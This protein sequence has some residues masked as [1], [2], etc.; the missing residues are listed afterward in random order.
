MIAAV[1]RCRIDSCRT[2]VLPLTSLQ[3]I[4]TAL[5]PP[6]LAVKVCDLLAQDF[7]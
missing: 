7:E 1:T 5:K 3:E 2:D 4:L 6:Y